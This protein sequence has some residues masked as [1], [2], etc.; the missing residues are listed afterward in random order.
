M[1]TTV[2]C[3]ARHR[4]ALGRKLRAVARASDR[5]AGLRAELQGKI[6]EV[7]GRYERRIAAAEAR[8]ERLREALEAF[9]RDNRNSLLP[10]DRK[11]LQTPRGTVGFRRSPPSVRLREGVTKPE[12]AEMLLRNDLSEFV[13][14]RRSPRRR[15]LRRAVTESR[16]DR[17]RLRECGM[18]FIEGEETFYCK[19]PKHA[20]ARQER[21]K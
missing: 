8:L 5:L 3:T 12:A 13:R 18:Q 1:S 9:C 21:S 20:P 4:A 7:R 19:V 17:E 16:F 10:E 2:R 6:A 15:A 11:S 14:V